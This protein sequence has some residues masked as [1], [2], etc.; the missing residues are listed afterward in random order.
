MNET[1][2]TQKKIIYSLSLPLSCDDEGK[3]EKEGEKR[4]ERKEK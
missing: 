2:Y 1:T 4:R 3:G